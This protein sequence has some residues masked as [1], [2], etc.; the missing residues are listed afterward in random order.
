MLNW[1][2]S[3]GDLFTS[4]KNQTPTPVPPERF[5]RRWRSL[6]MRQQQVAILVG[7]N[8]TYQQIGESLCISPHTARTH[9]RNALHK[10]QLGNKAELRQVLVI[11]EEQE[12]INLQRYSNYIDQR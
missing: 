7:L 10:L 3:I 11:L 5:R 12:V 8:Y 9:T 2:R 4:S 6:T 1:F